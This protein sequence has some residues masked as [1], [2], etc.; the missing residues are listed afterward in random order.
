MVR[1]DGAIADF[2][3]ERLPEGGGCNTEGSTTKGLQ[4]GVGGGDLC[5]RTVISRE[6]CKDGE[7]P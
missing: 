1:C 3:R 2:C 4:P 7:G 5:L 6:D